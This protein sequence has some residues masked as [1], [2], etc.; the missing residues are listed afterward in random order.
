MCLID[1]DQYCRD[2]GE[3]LIRSFLDN[4]PESVSN[5]KLPDLSLKNAYILVLGRKNGCSLEEV[6]PL[7]IA[8]RHFSMLESYEMLRIIFSSE[9]Y[10]D[11]TKYVVG[12]FNKAID[13]VKKKRQHAS[14]E[15]IVPKETE[16]E[17][18]ERWKCCQISMAV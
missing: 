15:V 5:F 8:L 17:R 11:G 7:F 1:G 10:Y 6:T 14:S 2:T 13:E 3:A 4:H 18:R 9:D 16:L 12:A